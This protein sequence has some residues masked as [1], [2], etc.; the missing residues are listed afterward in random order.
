V[1]DGLWIIAGAV[2]LLLAVCLLLL[3]QTWVWP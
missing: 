2:G 3:L 1:N